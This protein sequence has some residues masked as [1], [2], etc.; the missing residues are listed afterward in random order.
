MANLVPMTKSLPAAVISLVQLLENWRAMD[1]LPEGVTREELV[2][3]ALTLAPLM[4][5]SDPK[6]Y[7]VAL[8]R[9]FTVL[10]RPTKESL[11]VWRELLA[12]YPTKTLHMAV[13][14]VI[15]GHKWQ[16]PP[17]IAEMVEACQ[18]DASFKELCG[19]KH[20]I[21]TALWKLK[22]TSRSS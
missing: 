3:A 8:E 17:T 11:K 10:P 6:S 20:R 19:W 5:P 4:A 15:M 14:T 13:D 7:A 2:G 12:R 1:P 18:Q 22:M 9:L 21:D 16:T